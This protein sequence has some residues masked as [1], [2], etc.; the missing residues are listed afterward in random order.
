VLDNPSD[1]RPSP[2]S[3]AEAGELAEGLSQLTGCGVPLAE[4]LLVLADDVPSKSLRRAYQDLGHRL[5]SGML[6]DEALEDLGGRVPEH[7]CGL[8]A[9]GVATGRLGDVLSQFIRVQSRVHELRRGVWR[10]LA[11]PAVLLGLL[12]G[13][14]VLAKAFVVEP[15][16]DILATFSDTY[17]SFYSAKS[18]PEYPM[19][20]QLLL[21]MPGLDVLGGVTLGG[22]VVVIWLCLRCSTPRV[23]HRLAANLPLVGP[24]WRNGSLA[25]FAGLLAVLLEERV[26]L[27]K[28]L[29]LTGQGLYDR[30][31]ADAC[32]RMG[33]L[34]AAGHS[35]SDCFQGGGRLPVTLAPLVEW[36]TRHGTLPAVLRSAAEMFM[37]R[38]EAQAQFVGAV[39][40]PLMFLVILAGIGFLV[41]AMYLPLVTVIQML[42]G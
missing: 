40:P 4:G 7:L 21:A 34:T 31:L 35:L 30:D 8:A 10:S 18:G 28:A 5:Q 1:S 27:P 19:A 41:I 13:V 20:T 3:S 39:L 42:T 11:Y 29:K 24:I 25:G 15:L 2:L 16:A 36:G 6:L 38:S 9:A 32:Q 12:L 23:R 22:C 37:A 33:G 14:F 17:G 26:P